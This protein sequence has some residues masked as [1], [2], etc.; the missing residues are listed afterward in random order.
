MSTKHTSTLREIQMLKLKQTH[1]RINYGRLDIKCCRRSK[2][3]TLI[4]H[5]SCIMQNINIV[6]IYIE[7]GGHWSCLS[8]LTDFAA[9]HGTP[10]PL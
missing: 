6:Y 4:F 5:Y 10:H 1:K 2:T 8:N 3:E 9:P 7:R